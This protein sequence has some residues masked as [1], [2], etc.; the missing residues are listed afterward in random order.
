MGLKNFKK[1]IMA[2]DNSSKSMAY[3][4]FDGVDLIEYGEIM[5]V[6]A[7]IVSRA[8]SAAGQMRALRDQWHPDKIVYESAIYVNSNKTA[9]DLAF[10]L[11]AVITSIAD[12]KTKV[13]AITPVKWQSSIG[14]GLFNKQQKDALKAQY[15][16]KSATWIKAHIRT[17]R[18]QKTISIVNNEFNVN[19][20]SDNVADAI[21]IGA[22][23]SGRIK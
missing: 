22:F 5:F 17:L 12:N 1:R 8:I 13:E 11:G 20:E 18:K 21:G 3:A 19:I 10:C 14:N 16:D 2:I 15:P 9:A 23:A 7:D 6:G 4:I